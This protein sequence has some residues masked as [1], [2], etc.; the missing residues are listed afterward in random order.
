MPATLSPSAIRIASSSTSVRG[1]F[2]DRVLAQMAAKETRARAA[3]IEAEDVA[4]DVV[5]A[6]AACDVAI[7]IGNEPL[8]RLARALPRALEAEEALIDLGQDVGILIGGA[9][10][11]HAVDVLEMT[12]GIVES[13]RCRR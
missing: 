1:A 3:V 8:E 11:H 12:R 4:R 6:A 10:Q 5:E 2:A 9:A 7:G 13:R